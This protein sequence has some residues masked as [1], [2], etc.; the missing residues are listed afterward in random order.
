M[1]SWVGVLAVLDAGSARVLPAKWSYFRP[2]Q[3]LKII[4][5]DGNVISFD[6]EGRALAHLPAQK[7]VGDPLKAN[8]LAGDL[9]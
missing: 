5:V 4:H 6:S 7:S 1:I 8:N 2:P 3:S 9:P